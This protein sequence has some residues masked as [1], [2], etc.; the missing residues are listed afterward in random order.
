MRRPSFTVATFI[1]SIASALLSAPVTFGA[2]QS[3]MA[4][5][6]IAIL[7]F[8]RDPTGK[9][10]ADELHAALSVDPEL[11]LITR[12]LARAAAVGLGYQGSLNM[13][14]A[15][16]R[17]LGTAIGCDLFITG[18]AQVVRRSPSSGT[19]YFESYASIFIVDARSGA[20]VQWD[21][22]SL[23]ATHAADALAVLK[24]ELRRRAPLYATTLR[25][26]FAAQLQRTL[27]WQPTEKG[28]EESM[29]L[30]LTRDQGLDENIIPPQ[31][32]RRLQPAY[33]EEA[34]RAEAE[35][36]VDVLAWIDED[37]VVRRVE[38]V[39]WAGFGLDESVTQT[40]KRMFFRPAM[41]N[42]RPTPALVLLRYNFR[43]SAR[44]QRQR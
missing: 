35:A 21:R 15:E 44:S 12:D 8:N 4:R 30:D 11:A 10:L 14:R 38:V 39:R 29:Y 32:Y 36:T 7:D 19:I 33:T 34:A 41:R 1:L 6:R 22:P 37:G 9:Q 5:A 28:E 20:L 3:H 31:P 24:T 18:D 26:A 17:D 25:R 27:A 40:V 16:A 13:T 23:Q 43:R 42:Q 2:Q